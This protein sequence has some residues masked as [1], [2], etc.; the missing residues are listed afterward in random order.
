MLSSV[1]A[2]CGCVPTCCAACA[3]YKSHGASISAC[4]DR[5][6]PGRWRGP[7]VNAVL[8]TLAALRANRSGLARAVHQTL[9]PIRWGLRIAM[10]IH[11]SRVR[12]GAC[13]VCRGKA[14]FKGAACS[15]SCADPG[16]RCMPPQERQ[17]S[18]HVR[19][20][21]A[22]PRRVRNGV[23]VSCRCNHLPVRRGLTAEP[24]G[25]WW[26]VK[27]VRRC[28]GKRSSSH[29]VA[30]WDALCGWSSALSFAALRQHPLAY[31]E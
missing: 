9:A 16:R 8:S 3:R 5:V 29:T 17:P 25:S 28:R 31:I 15:D 12:A 27:V 18:G 11:L 20:G 13:S 21:P 2:V 24:C 14:A 22:A 10:S 23:A 30:V 1:C 4:R 6:R 19:G 7:P 26:C